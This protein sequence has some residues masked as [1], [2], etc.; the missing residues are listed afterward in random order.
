MALSVIFGKPGAGK[1]YF[2]VTKI[3]S[4][5][6]D[7]CRAELVSGVEHKRKIYTNLP[8]KRDAINDY[9]SKKIGRPVDAAKYIEV[10]EENFFIEE[11]TPGKFKKIDWWEKFP[12]GA[13][14]VIDEVQ[15]YLSNSKDSGDGA[16]LKDFQLYISTHRHR[17]HDLIFLTQH[18][19]NINKVCLNMAQDAY[20]VVNIKGRVLPWLGIPFADF[21]VL[22][23]A[24]GYKNQYANILYG[25]YLGRAFKPESTLHIL[26]SPDIYRL[27]KSHNNDDGEDRPSLQL[28]R[29]RAVLWFLRRHFWH[30]FI[31][32]ALVVFVVHMIFGVICSLPVVLSDKLSKQITD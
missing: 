2:A 23:E 27:Y 5:I 7:Y 32:A 31:K 9:I 30:L 12:E 28:S 25:N 13:F 1:S 17:K 4:E 18:T 21:Q 22:L 6:E 26:L 11:T 15:F 24:F 14:I 29:G 19:D 8:L 16:Y 20:H 10:L 3:V